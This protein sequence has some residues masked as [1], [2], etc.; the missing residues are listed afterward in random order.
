MKRTGKSIAAASVAFAILC[1]AGLFSGAPSASVSADGNR[2]VTENCVDL[3]LIAGQ[4]NAAGYSARGTKLFGSFTNVSYAGEIDKQRIGGEC[5]QS[6]LTY[7]FRTSVTDGLGRGEYNIGPEYGIAETINESYG[8]GRRALIFKSAAG[9]TGLRNTKTGQSDL[10]GNWYPR[11]EW[12]GSVNAAE[13]PTGVQYRNFVDNF[14][15]VWRQLCEQGYTPRVQGMAWMQGEDDL[16]AHTQY[17]ALLE[18]FITD[19]RT[20]LVEITGDGELSKMP[21]VI[22]EIATSFASYENPLVP[23]FVEVQRAVAAKME[24]V[25]TVKTDDLIIVGKNGL[26]GTDQY[27]FSKNDARTLGKRFGE[28]LLENRRTE[29]VYAGT[30]GNGSISGSFDGSGTR[31]TVSVTPNNGYL[32]KSLWVDGVDVTAGVT[33]GAYVID[34]PPKGVNVYAE[35]EKLPFTISYL[36]DESQGSVG[37]PATL[38]EMQTL[39]VDV[40]PAD[41]YEVESVKFGDKTLTKSGDQYM[42]GFVEESGAVEVTFRKIRT[43]EGGGGGLSDEMLGVAI[44]VP[45]GVAVAAGATTA[46]VLIGKKKKR[47]K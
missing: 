26:V 10:Y 3:Y 36:F 11:S 37:G 44:G 14:A 16:G 45:V 29:D 27:H 24:N 7:P 23:P 41:G 25:Y 46:G 19:L 30:D 39:F 31:L 2:T 35:F 1:G 12:N 5:A 21:F 40:T 32:L 15:L 42:L 38:R 20:D 22:G 33:D 34:N 6:Y 47:N 9:G 43:G 13:S 17:G 8:N 28:V 4:S 18:T